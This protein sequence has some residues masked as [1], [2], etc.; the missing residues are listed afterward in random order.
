MTKI[1]DMTTDQLK[2]ASRHMDGQN[3]GGDGYNA[4][5]EEMGRRARAAE[6]LRPKSAA[7]QLQ[8]AYRALDRA[9]NSIARESGTYN[10]NEVDAINAKIAALKAEIAVDQAAADKAF[11]AVW[12]LDLTRARRRA[13]NDY[14]RA[15]P[16]TRGKIH[17]PTYDAWL[18]AQ[19]WSQADLGR[20]ITLHRIK[21][22]RA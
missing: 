6:A 4:Y 9:D 7:E 5:R 11:L 19:G 15:M 10:A 8:A 13:N 12:T 18:A 3:E 22:E 2:A 20:A 1:S 21:E 17:G 16:L 14:V